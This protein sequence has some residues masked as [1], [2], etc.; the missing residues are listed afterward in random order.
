MITGVSGDVVRVIEA[1]GGDTENAPDWIFALPLTQFAAP[2]AKMTTAMPERLIHHCDH[3][4]Q[5]R[6]LAL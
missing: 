6:E 4:N 3:G 2:L 1:G 5:Q